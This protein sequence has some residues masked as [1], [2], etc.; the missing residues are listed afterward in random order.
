MSNIIQKN[1]STAALRR[2]FLLIYSDTD[3]I[4]PWAGSVTGVKAKLSFR[5]G[6][7]ADSTND[8]ARLAGA[9]HYVELTQTEANTTTG[10]VT[11]RVPAASGRLEGLGLAE[12]V[13][14]DP[15]LAG[16]FS[17]QQPELT[18]APAVNN[19]API[20]MLR[21][22]YH[23]FRNQRITTST[24]DTLKRNDGT[25]TLASASLSDSSGTLTWGEY[26]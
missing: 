23:Y 4:T 8:I 18:A 12:I 10:A 13:A 11:A 26:A 22:L 19:A 21:W 17:V 14:Y 5:G 16:D 25:T 6:S 9:I 15:R 3:G 2:V 24:T 7:E 20:D 1:E